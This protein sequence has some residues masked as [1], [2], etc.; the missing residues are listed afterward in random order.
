MC[1][2]AE[3]TSGSSLLGISDDVRS[4]CSFVS[5][6]ETTFFYVPL[7]KGRFASASQ[8][9]QTGRR[10][11]ADRAFILSA[12]EM[13]IGFDLDTNHCFFMERTHRCGITHASSS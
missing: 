4:F 10:V 7:P 13:S 6:E 5:V 8:V 3:A 1:F 11:P 2:D 9:V 12:F